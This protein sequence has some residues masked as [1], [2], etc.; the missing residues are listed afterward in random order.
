MSAPLQTA[1]ASLADGLVAYWEFEGNANN[2][3]LASGGSAYNGALLG[4]ATTTGTPRVGSGSLALNGSGAYMSVGAIVQTSTAWSVAAWFYNTSKAG[5]GNSRQFVFESVPTFPISFALVQ[6]SATHT[7]LQTFT[8]FSDNNQASTAEPVF[9]DTDIINVWNH[10]V[11]AY[12][13]PTPT[14]DGSILTYINGL[15]ES[16]ITVPMAV[17]VQANMTGFN[18][19]TYRDANARWFDGFI[20]E[21]AMWNRTLS[22]GEAEEVYQLGLMGLPIVVIPEPGAAI[23]LLFGAAVVLAAAR[24]RRRV[25]A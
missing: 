2:N 18:V 9:A 1:S 17:T 4:G 21:V 20:D 19:G 16:A 5:T 22:A 3:P 6:S 24:R 7:L 23:G 13:P 15:E 11:V 12:T 8:R 10:V 25:G 14:Q